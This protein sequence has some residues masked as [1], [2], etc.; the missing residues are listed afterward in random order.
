MRNYI[1][2]KSLKAGIKNKA[3]IEKLLKVKSLSTLKKELQEVFNLY[4]RLR[5]TRYDKQ[6]PYF[7]C[8]SCSDPK[9]LDQMNAGHLYPV[10]S[11]E[12]IRFDE[13]N[14]NGQCIACNLHKHGNQL[15]YY[16][17]LIKKIG[18]KRVEMLDIKRHNLSKLAR[19]EVELL[20]THYKQKVEQ[21]RK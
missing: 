8:I 16:K 13:D 3:K 20:I 17:N 1:G 18:I 15:A 5:D 9:T 6:T 7:I 19:F 14:T 10:G 4:I 21:L 2:P 11:N 12:S